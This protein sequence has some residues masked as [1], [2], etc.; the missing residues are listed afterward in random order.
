MKAIGQDLQDA[1]K[2]YSKFTLTP[3]Y[4]QDKE[5]KLNRT[6][7]LIKG[8]THDSFEQDNYTLFLPAFNSEEIELSLNWKK[9]GS[10]HFFFLESLNEIPFRHNGSLVLSSIISRGDQLDIGHNRLRFDT[11]TTLQEDEFDLDERI[12]DSNL[13]IL[14]EGE[15]GTGKS[16]LAREVH[17]RSRRVGP[18]VHLNLASFSPSLVESEIFGHIKGAFTGAISNKVGALKEANF[19]TLFL[20]EIDSLPLELQTK[21]LLFLDSKTF[22][23][24]GSNKE[25]SVDVRIIFASGRNLMR[26][27]EE[28]TFRKD[29]YF[30][31]SSGSFKRLAPLREDRRRLATLINEFEIKQDCI[32][33]R[34]LREFYM[35]V[36]WPGNIRQ[37]MGH[38]NKKAVLSNGRK[39]DYDFLD[40]ELM[41][42]PAELKSDLYENTIT[43]RELKLKYFNTVL[44]RVNGDYRSAAK[45]LDVSINTVKNV[46]SKAS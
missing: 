39:V 9:F 29:M 13:N 32:L 46:L 25:E 26:L 3:L 24:V 1:V 42:L 31:I 20:D 36:D 37:L 4:G 11:S 28:G 17:K 35:K 10:G 30:R 45:K 44:A 38:L 34:R 22:R 12:V 19:G 8:S 21:L 7:Y 15:T 27:V 43:Y 6:H 33:T 5:I 18:F 14:I 16:Y 23:A 40:D 2:Y 41:F